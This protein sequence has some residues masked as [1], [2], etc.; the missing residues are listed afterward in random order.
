MDLTRVVPPIYFFAAIL[1]MVA[2]HIFIPL[3][4]WAP[5]SINLTG[6]LPLAAGLLFAAHGASLFKKHDTPIKPLTQSTALVR[7]GLYRYT[8]NPMY[9][10]M[11]LC[12]LGI[13]ILLGSLSPVLPVVA[14][15]LVL[16]TFIRR[17]EALMRTTFKEEFDDY[18]RDVRRWL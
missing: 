2:L 16:S 12:L 10:G 8:R 6:I 18:C 17:E 11:L 14:M 7:E 3:A 4:V 9:M 1:A 15:F 13:W 5:D